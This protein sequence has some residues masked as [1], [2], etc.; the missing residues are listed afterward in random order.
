[1]SDAIRNKGLKSR[2]RFS[3]SLDKDLAS[4]L[5]TLSA[6]TRIPKSKLIDEAVELLLEKH[7][8]SN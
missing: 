6:N 5:E 3:T 4:K 2:I 7:N 8:T 1:M